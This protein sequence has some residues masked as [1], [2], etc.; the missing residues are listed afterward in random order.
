MWTCPICITVNGR[1]EKIA[2]LVA[3]M[4]TTGRQGKI[5]SHRARENRKILISIIVVSKN[6]KDRIRRCL[7]S[8]LDQSYKNLE[9]IV[10]DS[11]DDGTERIL[12]QYRKQDQRVKVVF[13]EP[14]GVGAARY[15]G[16][17]NATGEAIGSLDTDC[18]LNK[19]LM[20]KV[21]AAFGNP[22]VM[23]VQARVIVSS[24]ERTPFSGLVREYEKDVLGL[25]EEYFEFVA[26]RKELIQ[27][28]GQFDPNL[29]VGEDKVYSRRLE[30]IVAQF[31]REGY[32]FPT[33]D[34]EIIE[35]KTREGFREYW[36]KIMWYGEAYVHKEYLRIDQ[37]IVRLAVS[38][39]LFIAPVVLVWSYLVGIDL[40]P[41]VIPIVAGI[42]FVYFKAIGKTAASKAILFPIILYYK[43][44][45]TALGFLRAAARSLLK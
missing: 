33:I 18:Y 30:P 44:I 17:K 22:R 24:E 23:G 12:D 35:T 38:F 45:F 3:R 41:L 11:S 32:E 8:I 21:A 31:E 5:G 19:N 26:L 43:A 15:E 1:P 6:E 16:G 36:R 29:H 2:E 42:G 27:K 34:A 13:Q 7:D 14:R 28:T 39:Y 4:E 40:T 25:P 9:I 37:N 20:E 10:V